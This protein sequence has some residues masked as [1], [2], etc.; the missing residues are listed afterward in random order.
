MGQDRSPN[1]ERRHEVACPLDRGAGMNV[2]TPPRSQ[3]VPMG[4]GIID[5]TPPLRNGMPIYP[6][7]PG[8]SVRTV[9]DVSAGAHSTLS[10]MTTG[11]H[12]GL[13]VDAPAHF[14][15]GASILDEMPLERLI[16]PARVVE[17]H[18]VGAIEAE[19]LEA[20]DIETHERLLLKT[21]NSRLWQRDDFVAG[22]THLSTGAALFL[23]GLGLACVGID[24]LSIG[25]FQ[26][27][28]TEVHRALLG[29]GTLVIEG[30][31]LSAAKPG[32]YELIC[33]PLRL[34]GAEASLAR[35][36]L[37]PLAGSA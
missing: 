26:S 27:N 8:F 24:Y 13:H 35:A 34:A 28:G 23:G 37:R 32:R 1:C 29:A 11:T 7:N 9:R 22:Y 36:V 21:P 6:G 4:A 16:G 31:D 5:I 25:G 12:S 15:A 20:L 30:L 3:G 17:L 14:I 33:L 18:T 19:E 2:T 10:E